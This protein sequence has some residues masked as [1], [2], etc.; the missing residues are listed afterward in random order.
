METLN[1][2]K[3]LLG[4]YVDICLSG[5][6][7]KSRLMDLSSMLFSEFEKIQ[8][9]MSFHSPD[10]E[11]SIINRK[12][13]QQPCKLSNHTY[14]VIE[15]ALQ[16]SA[17][18]D[19]LFDISIA[20][21]LVA[22]QL[23]PDHGIPSHHSASWKDISLVDNC[24]KFAKPLLIDLGGIAKG[25]AVDQAFSLLASE[26]LN[27]VIN[28][29]GDL[30]ISHWQG[31]TVSI[32]VDG[33][34]GALRE[35]PMANSAVATSANYYTENGYPI[36]CPLTQSTVI[37]NKVVSVFAPNCML[38]DAL[39]KVVFINS[40]N[41]QLLDSLNAVA[42]IFHPHQS[43]SDSPVSICHTSL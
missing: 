39:S 16:L 28:A 29:G 9:L 6:M 25:Y 19:G 15:Q 2:C 34:N 3:P 18:S 24:I 13:Y 5:E 7:S 10:S 4:T 31:K 21:K 17:A 1:R 27:I 36:I 30:R 37:D 33:E 41:K 42:S 26:P 32:Q 23:L 12:A 35:I 43:K 40:S 14:K 38:A 22:Q 11:L 8:T 20:P